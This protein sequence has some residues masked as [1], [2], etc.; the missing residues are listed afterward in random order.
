MGYVSQH[1]QYSRLRAQQ[2]SKLHIQRIN[3]RWI[4]DLGCQEGTRP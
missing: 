1:W 3:G 4:D 2:I